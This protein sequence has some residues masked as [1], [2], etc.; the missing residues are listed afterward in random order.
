MAR[1]IVDISV[2]LRAG[3]ASDP[4]GLLPEIDYLAHGETADQMLSFF[5]GATVDDLPDREGWALENVRISTHNGTHL[6]APYHYASTMDG[7]LRAITTRRSSGRA[8]GPGARSATRTSRSCTTSS[9]CPRTAFRSPAS[10]CRSRAGR[11]GGRGRSRS[12]TIRR[13]DGA[14]APV[15]EVAGTLSTRLSVA[16]VRPDRLLAT[17]ARGLSPGDARWACTFSPRAARSASARVIWLL[18]LGISATRPRAA[19]RGGFMHAPGARRPNPRRRD[20][21]HC[22]IAVR[23]PRGGTGSRCGRSR[24]R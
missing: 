22:A 7:G 23:R 21:H 24:T 9:R 1:R 4:P 8:I 15:D 13:G 16:V 14:Q 17:R 10:R 3:I 11:P 6:D 20:R 19:T 18:G 5:P 2:P 12:S